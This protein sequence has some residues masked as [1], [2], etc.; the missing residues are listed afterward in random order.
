[1]SKDFI[2]S[3]LEEGFFFTPSFWIIF[4]I[5]LILSCIQIS[6]I[7]INPWSFIFRTIGNWINKDTSNELR[8]IGETL[9]RINEDNRNIHKSLDSLNYKIKEHM[10]VD[11][12]VRI[13]QFEDEMIHGIHHT[14]ENFNQILSDITFYEHFCMTYPDFRNS[15]ANLSIAHIK[16]VYER[17][18]R[19]KK[20]ID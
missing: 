17:C 16:E 18:L 2:E 5:G 7:E 6:P 13:L 1:M 8:K 3:T 10:A 19:E 20:F 12:R 11:S 14:R 15:I 9:T 4:I